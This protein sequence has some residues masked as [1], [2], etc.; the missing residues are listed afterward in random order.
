[1]E[2]LE[3]KCLS[4]VTA[5]GNGMVLHAIRTEARLQTVGGVCTV[6]NVCTECTGKHQN[7]LSTSNY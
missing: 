1:M 7:H 4:L 5:V 3:A 2:E 6:C